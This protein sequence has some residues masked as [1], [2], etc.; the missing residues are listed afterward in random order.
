MVSEKEKAKL[1]NLGEKY[2]KKGKLLE[3]VDVYERLLKEES[4][5]INIRNIIGDLYIKLKKEDKAI[6]HFK[7]IAQHY[8]E[9][10][11]HTK[12][13]AVYK[14]ISKLDPG[15]I[16]VSLQLADLY[17]NLGFYSEAKEEYL[18]A[19]KIL[20][21]ENRIREAISLYEKILKFDKG[22]I[23]CRLS[24]AELYKEEDMISQAVVKLNEVAESMM[25]KKETQEAEEILNSA[26]EL[27]SGHE[28]TLANYI[29]LLKKEDRKDEAYLFLDTVLGEN[30]DNIKALTLLGKLY[31]EEK[32]FEK[33]EEVFSKAFSLDE[34]NNEVRVKLGNICIQKRDCDRAFELFEPLVNVF[35]KNRKYNKAIGLLGL[36]LKSK[37]PHIPTL[38][39]LASIYKLKN[40]KENLKV[41]SRVMLEAYLKNGMDKDALSHLREMEKLFPDDDEWKEKYSNLGKKID[42]KE[43]KEIPDS[44]DESRA[45]QKSFEKVD[46]YIKQGLIKNA[47]KVLEKIK[48]KYPGNIEVD[49]RIETFELEHGDR[50]VKGIPLKKEKA[51]IERINE[52]I[53]AG[54]QNGIQNENKELKITAADIFKDTDIIP[55]GMTKEDNYYNLSNSVR[56]EQDS[57]KDIMKQQKEGYITNVE[58]GLF[59]IVRQFKKSIKEKIDSAD[60]ESRYNLGLALM[61]QE[62][63]DEAI[64]ELK[65]ASCEKSLALECCSLISY[66]YR[67]KKDFKDAITW[68]EM[69]LDFAKEGSNQSFELKYELASIYEESNSIKKALSLYDEVKNW[70]SNYRNIEKK[71]DKLESRQ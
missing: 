5:D 20:K 36:I 15:N 28:R 35:I 14:K 1:L 52:V 23:D 6:E 64:E 18:A 40:E 37:E 4:R 8:K 53:K 30:K 65:I 70:N 24:L 63:Y 19:A 3:A 50:I 39:K 42:Q 11:L 26:I 67:Q 27:H 33:A 54:P 38:E 31:Y 49:R 2:T 25:N 56:E 13:M 57:I 41:I 58:M 21:R 22:D 48:K 55:E 29:E 47:K 62:L 43:E 71:I 7:M 10:G 32:D 66:C 46:L 68:M 44:D 51:F 34:T 9:K 61:E 17:S 45:V 16:E 69:A 60:Y 59:D 12:L